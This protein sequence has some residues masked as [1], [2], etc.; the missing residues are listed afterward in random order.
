MSERVSESRRLSEL[1][2]PW[3]S[4]DDS[5]WERIFRYVPLRTRVQMEVVCRRWCKAIRSKRLWSV[6]ELGTDAEMS[7]KV[8]EES[9]QEIWK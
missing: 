5:L 9:F 6:I 4:L 2:I 3:D 8:G 7:T 1:L